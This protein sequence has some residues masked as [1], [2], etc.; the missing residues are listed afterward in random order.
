MKNFLGTLL[1]FGLIAFIWYSVLNES[2]F[3]KIGKIE[4][5]LWNVEDS[6]LRLEKGQKE[7]LVKIGEIQKSLVDLEKKLN[8]LKDQNKYTQ[9]LVEKNSIDSKFYSQVTTSVQYYEELQKLKEKYT[10]QVQ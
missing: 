8:D 7:I 5:R 4:Q 1:V 10:I 9:Y 3:W 2:F 6:L